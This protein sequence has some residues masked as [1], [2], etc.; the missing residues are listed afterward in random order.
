MAKASASRAGSSK[1]SVS[2]AMTQGRKLANE[3][4]AR[5]RA[6]IQRRNVAPKRPA[7]RAVGAPRRVPT[8]LVKASVASA[9]A[10]IAE[11][12]SWFDYPMHDVLKVLEDDYRYDV[13]SVSHRGDTVES[14]AYAPGQLDDFSRRV[15]KVLR[16]GT[17]PKAILLSGGGNDIAGDEFAILLNHAASTRSGLNP[18]IVGGVID[19]RLFEAYL[20]IL[21]AIS[22]LS[23]SLSGT[24]IPILLHGYD[25]AIP[26][27]RGF[28]GG[29]WFLPGP[30]L[31]PGLRQKG[32][33]DKARC[34]ALV[35]ELIDRFNAMLARIVRQPGFAHVKYLDLRG[36]L[37]DKGD[38]K[39][40]WANELH[41]TKK[42]FEAVAKK[43]AAQIR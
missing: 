7:G 17:V 28:L 5:R 30:W 6:I 9:G 40:W 1:A 4:L 19:D 31:E 26:D 38:Y 36:T 42:G 25:Y 13:E 3:T 21:S 32:Y 18:T 14:M 8:G 24:R 39:T 20:T 41:P 34:L 16:S 23:E 35:H 10:V 11:G 15:E 12:D 22:A 27:G 2:K 43:F 33:N 37:S 29:A